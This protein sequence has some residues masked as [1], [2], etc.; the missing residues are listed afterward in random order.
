MPIPVPWRAAP[1]E[2]VPFVFTTGVPLCSV[3]LVAIT[4]REIAGL[5]LVGGVVVV[6]FLALWA[7]VGWLVKEDSHANLGDDQPR[8]HH[9]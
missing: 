6:M 8:R 4:D 3:S 7:F 2:R 9:E 1:G 5:V